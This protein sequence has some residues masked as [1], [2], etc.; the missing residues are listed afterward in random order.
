MA[1][2]AMA[3]IVNEGFTPMLA[4]TAETSVTY[5]LSYSDTR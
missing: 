1:R 2:S 5:T 4:E 3:V